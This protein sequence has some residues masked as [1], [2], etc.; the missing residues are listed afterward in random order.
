MTAL[1]H[2]FTELPVHHVIDPVEHFLC[3][4]GSIIVAPSHYLGVEVYYRVLGITSQVSDAV[5]DCHQMFAYAVLSGFDKCLE[6]FSS[7]LAVL[8]TVESKEVE[9]RFVSF[10]LT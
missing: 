1:F 5:F 8:S 9:S 7:G 10:I 2:P 3:Y 6:F 4:A